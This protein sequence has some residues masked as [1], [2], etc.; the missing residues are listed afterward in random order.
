MI[1]TGLLKGGN[2]KV[3]TNETLSPLLVNFIGIG[4]KEIHENCILHESHH[5]TTP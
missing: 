2:L 3:W 4:G 5:Y 1:I